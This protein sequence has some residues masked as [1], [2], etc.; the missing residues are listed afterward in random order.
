MRT[1]RNVKKDIEAL[2]KDIKNIMTV[3]VRETDANIDKVIANESGSGLQFRGLVP[4]IMIEVR[5][6]KHTDLSKIID[7]LRQT[8]VFQRVEIVTP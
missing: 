4:D 5:M 2:K 1:K 7:K 6:D 8:K 3:R